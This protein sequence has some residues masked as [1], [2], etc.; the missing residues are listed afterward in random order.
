MA[1]SSDRTL[2]MDPA[3]ADSA[4][5]RCHGTETTGNAGVEP[6]EPLAAEPVAS[7]Q[8]DVAAATSA[9][10]ALLP[11]LVEGALSL[12]VMRALRK[13]GIGVAVAYCSRDNGGLA[14]DPMRDFAA[15]G[16]LIDL[17]AT[18][19]EHYIDALRHEIVAR[20]TRLL[21][22]IGAASLY[23]V[24][25]YLKEWNPRLKIVD[26]LYNEVGHTVSHFLFEN[27]FD[28]VIVESEHMRR[29]VRNCT[30]RPDADIRVVENGIDLQTF[31]PAPVEFTPDRLRV[32]YIGRMSP[33]KNP[34]GFVDL[35]EALATRIPSASFS[36]VGGGPMT[37][38]VR[39]R[40][41]SSSLGNRVAYSGPARVNDV[42]STIRALDV[43]V[44]P[45]TLDGRPAVIMEANACGVPVIG[46]PVGGIPELIEEGRNGFVAAPRDVDRIAH[47]LQ[48]L[49]DDR[50]ALANLRHTCRVVAEQRF[51]YDRMIDDYAAALDR[52]I[53]QGDRAASVGAG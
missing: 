52:F 12:N 6:E 2:S 10:I 9:I 36:L 8:G 29:F 19:P 4:T 23:P 28:G 1:G 53:T 26:I 40:V 16:R 46:S 49:N 51:A 18:P 39:R 14:S 15:E 48:H 38:E 11:Y 25:P 31:T 3:V 22:Q 42:A 24:L 5:A 32:G 27:C 20:E 45:S 30:L 7:R 17:S 33:E 47:I 37:E 21:L 34:L 50:D 43:L 44:V 41:D 13:R 35:A